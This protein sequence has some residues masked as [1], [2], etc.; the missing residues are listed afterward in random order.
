MKKL[1]WAERKVYV[2]AYPDSWGVRMLSEENAIKLL[3]AERG[4]M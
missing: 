4:G 1:D 3:R 2:L